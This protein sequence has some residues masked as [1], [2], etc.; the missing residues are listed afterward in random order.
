M[1]ASCNASFAGTQQQCRRQLLHQDAA[2]A[3]TEN[4]SQD[5]HFKI[6]CKTRS[7]KNMKNQAIGYDYIY[8]AV[9][10][11]RLNVQST[12]DILKEIQ[13][14]SVAACTGKHPW[15]TKAFVCTVCEIKHHKVACSGILADGFREKRPRQWTKHTSI[16]LLEAMDA[17]IVEVIAGSDFS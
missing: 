15:S 12:A 3:A 16:T 8:I 4:V 6:V 13:D 7:S 5:S 11:C 17:Y 14:E 10:G 9:N 2:N 1:G